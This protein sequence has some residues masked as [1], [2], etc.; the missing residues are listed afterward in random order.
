MSLTKWVAFLS[1]K[2]IAYFPGRIKDTGLGSGLLHCTSVSHRGHTPCS[3]STPHHSQA[4]Q[5]HI[6]AAAFHHLQFDKPKHLTARVSKET[7][8]LWMLNALKC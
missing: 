5:L 4:G 8:T 1:W 3:S 2:Y 7:A 6:C